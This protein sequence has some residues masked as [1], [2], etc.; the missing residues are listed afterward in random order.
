[1][2]AQGRTANRSNTAGLKAGAS[3]LVLRMAR[4][5]QCA[6]CPKGKVKANPARRAEVVPDGAGLEGGR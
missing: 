2:I 6:G 4:R 5:A 1:M 3:D